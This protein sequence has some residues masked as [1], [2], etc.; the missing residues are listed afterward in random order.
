MAYRIVTLISSTNAVECVDEDRVR[1]LTEEFG[2]QDVRT[3]VPG[4]SLDFRLP[5][6][7]GS[8]GYV[9][10]DIS[11]ELIDWY[12]AKFETESGATFEP[13]PN[14]YVSWTVSR[15]MNLEMMH[16]VTDVVLPGQVVTA[17]D[18]ISGFNVRWR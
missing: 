9:E 7:N 12:A 15:E 8:D 14:V 1:R 16:D 17:W 4:T 5:F 6:G 2:V 3:L 10:V 18:D 11:P 13:M